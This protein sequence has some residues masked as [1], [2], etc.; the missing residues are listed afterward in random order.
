MP[1]YQITFTDG[2]IFN[3]GD[4]LK[5]SKWAEIPDKEILCLEFFI[6]DNDSII[7]RNYESYAAITEAL[8]AVLKKVGNCPK[9]GHIGK[10]AQAVTKHGEGKTSKK[11]VARCRKCDWVGQVT[12][13]INTNENEGD[14]YKYV[15][16]LK[17]GIVK[18]YRISLGGVK[19]K[20]KYQKGDITKREYPKGKEYKGREPVA[21]IA[22][23]RG[24]K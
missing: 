8:K 21:D 1:L 3:G 9:C 6:D 22:W 5:D 13:L 7:L 17:D 2:S 14:V 24:I 10:L 15:M 20:D 23:K 18:S 16:G 4:T 12:E 11:L 19:G